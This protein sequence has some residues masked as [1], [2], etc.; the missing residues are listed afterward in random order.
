M[1]ELEEQQVVALEADRTIT[2]PRKVGTALL[3]EPRARVVGG[4]LSD[5]RAWQERALTP[6][7]RANDAYIR[8]FKDIHAGQRCIII[9]NGPSLNETDLSLLRDE[10]TFGLN[11]IYMMYDK[12]GFEPTY[13]TVANRYVVAQCAEDFRSI[14]SPLFT[15]TRNRKHLDGAP[16][17][18]YLSYL[19][20]PRFSKDLSRGIWEGATVTYVAMQIAYYMGFHDVILV[21]VDH[22]FAVSGPN[23]QLVVSSGP[24]ASHF[25]PNYFGKGFKWELPNLDTSEEAYRLAKQTFEADGRS[26]VDATVGGALT[27]FPKTSLQEALGR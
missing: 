23:H 1:S 14:K 19:V 26:I 3:G 17:T 24:D 27:V 4:V 15:T 25:D 6:K 8:R 20:G 12:L 22:R 18:A 21:G 13:L 2:W 10:F 7:G 16:D 11:R 9:G 5:I